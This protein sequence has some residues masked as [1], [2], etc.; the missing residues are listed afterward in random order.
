MDHLKSTR[1]FTLQHLRFLVIDE[2][3]RLLSQNFN[4]WLKVLIAHIE[5]RE[6]GPDGVDDSTTEGRQEKHVDLDSVMET[7]SL[8]PQLVDSRFPLLDASIPQ[9]RASSVSYILHLSFD[10]M[11]LTLCAVTPRLR[12]CCSQPH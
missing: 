8:A 7:D 10:W 5:N 4:D 6:G 9:T 2:A 12:S 1:N 11:R 3:D